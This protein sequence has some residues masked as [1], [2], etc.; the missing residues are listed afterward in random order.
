MWVFN[1]LY[2]RTYL[3]TFMWQGLTATAEQRLVNRASFMAAEPH[4][5]SPREWKYVNVRHRFIVLENS[6]DHGTQRVGFE[7]NC[8]QALTRSCASDLVGTNRSHCELDLAICR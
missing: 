4:G 5:I 3:P 1:A 8:E 2:S 6:M 7:L